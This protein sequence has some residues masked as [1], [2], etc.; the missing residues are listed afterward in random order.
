MHQLNPD[1]KIPEKNQLKTLYNDHH[2]ETKDKVLNSLAPIEHFC[3]TSNVWTT[4]YQ[5]KSY[6]GSTCHYLDVNMRSKSIKLGIFQLNFENNAENLAEF[7][8]NKLNEYGIYERLY[9]M[10]VD[11]SIL[12]RKCCQSLN[13]EFLGCINHLLHLIVNRF[14]NVHNRNHRK[15]S[16]HKL[17]NVAEPISEYKKEVSCNFDNEV[18]EDNI[19]DD[20][21][22]DEDHHQNDENDPLNE[23]FEY[24]D[25]IRLDIFPQFKEYS[26]LELEILELMNGILKKMKCLVS[27]FNK[28]SYLNNQL[29]EKQKNLENPLTFNFKDQ[30]L[31][32]SINI[33]IC[34][35][36]ERYIQLKSQAEEVIREQAKSNNKKTIYHKYQKTFLTQSELDVVVVL[37]DMLKP[38]LFVAK[39]LKNHKFLRID[40]VIHSI[41]YIRYKISEFT[42]ENE[43]HINQI[44]SLMLNSFNFYVEKFELLS[45]RLIISAALLSPKYRSFRFSLPSEKQNFIRIGKEFIMETLIKINRLHETDHSGSDKTLRSNLSFFTELHSDENGYN[46]HIKHVYSALENEFSHY[47]KDESRSDFVEYWQTKKLEY[48]LLFRVARVIFSCPATSSPNELVLMEN[49]FANKSNCLTHQA[50]EKLLQIYGGLIL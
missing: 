1:F 13:S 47:M 46:R 12:M 43:Q 11:N 42:H 29:L 49:S 26:G 14:L 21:N 31:E 2:N 20:Y 35:Q 44:K 36:I 7:L 33:T 5:T 22:D 8:R 30:E 3:V 9:F 32:T 19:D 48:P 40:L 50:F 6:I 37:R 15:S 17:T 4:Q 24:K 25:P 39:T 27:A 23:L 28:Y 34:H 38:F 41:L 10:V 16:F 45:N 18:Y